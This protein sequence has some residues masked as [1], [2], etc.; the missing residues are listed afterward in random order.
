MFFVER[1]KKT[2]KKCKFLKYGWALSQNSSHT[3]KPILIRHSD[4]SSRSSFVCHTKKEC[5]K[6]QPWELLKSEKEARKKSEKKHL[7]TQ[8]SWNNLMK[9]SAKKNYSTSEALSAS[10][11]GVVLVVCVSVLGLRSSY[12]LLYIFFLTFI[13]ITCSFLTF[14]ST[15]GAFEDSR[16]LRFARF[17]STH[18][19]GMDGFKSPQPAFFL[20]NDRF[21]KTVESWSLS[22]KDT[23]TNRFVSKRK[24]WNFSLRISRSAGPKDFAGKFGNF[25]S[26]SCPEKKNKKN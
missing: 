9:P 15:D 8:R 14:V 12:M 19:R 18:T 10:A 1:K 22:I 13:L 20:L 11:P 6:T 5:S 24:N 23:K 3:R 17:H 4:E 21:K 16:S 26:Q 25:P 7:Q 2:W